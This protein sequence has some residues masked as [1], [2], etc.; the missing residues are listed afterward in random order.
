MIKKYDKAWDDVHKVEALG[1]AVHPGFL[2][3]FKK[4]SGGEK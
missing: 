4:T 3:A 1:G 2:E